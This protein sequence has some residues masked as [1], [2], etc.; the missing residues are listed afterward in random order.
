MS[1]Q[2]CPSLAELSGFVLGT[3]P[4]PELDKVAQHLDGCPSCEAAALALEHIS[5]PVVAAIRHQ[6]SGSPDLASHASDVGASLPERLGDFR[7]LREIGRG[8]MGLVYEAEQVSLSRRVALKVL[9]RRALLEAES[10][11][12]FRRESRAAAGLHHTNIVPVFG[13]GEQDGLHYFVM[14]LIPGVGLDRVLREL[15]QAPT[16]TRPTPSQVGHAAPGSSLQAVVQG[17]LSGSLT[18]P[19]AGMT[20]GHDGSP[21]PA[22]THA[23]P[24]SA[25]TAS[26]SSGSGR[27]YWLAVARVGIQV[28][29]ALQHAHAH[30]VIHRDIKPSNLLLDLQGTVWVTDF[31]LA[32]AAAEEQALTHSGDI[33]GTVRYMAPERFEGTSDGR[34][35]IYSLGVTLYELLTFRDAFPSTDRN[36]LLRRMLNTEPPRPRRVN[37]DVPRDLETIVLKGIARDPAH[38]YQTAAE[39]AADLRRFLEDRPVRARQITAPERLWRLCRR[40]P[41]TAG[42]LAALLVV[43]VAGL[44]GVA[45]QWRRAEGKA[46]DEA[47]ARRHAESARE[48]ARAHLYLSGV[49]QA[50]LEWRLNNVAAADRLLDQC[51]T[52]RRGW[53]WHYLRGVNRPELATLSNPTL[54]MLFGVAFSP[55][56]RL[57]AFTGWDYYRNFQAKVPTPVEVWDI[58]SGKRVHTLAATG[59]GLHP[60]FSPDGRILAVHSAWYPV[61]L[62][63]VAT[64]K[65]LQ[66]WEEKGGADFS[67]DGRLLAVGGLKDI[68][69]REV[70]TGRLVHHFPSQRGR[71]HFSP[72]GRL[73]AVCAEKAVELRAAD[74]GAEVGRLPFGPT[75]QV[76]P[77][78][79][80]LGADV[81]FSPDGKLL[82]TATNPPRVWDVAA[83]RPLA[84]LSGHAGIVPGVAF[85]PDGRHIATAGADATVRLWDAQTGVEL[86]VLRGHRGLVACIAFHPDGW[87]LATGGRQPGDVKL[88]DLTRHPEHVT[89]R[90]SNPH[91]LAFDAAGRLKVLTILGRIRSLDPQSGQ[92]DDGPRIQLTPKVVSP[93]TLAVFTG[94]SRLVAA[95]SAD[96]HT[97]KVFDAA[98]GQE[99]AALHGLDVMPRHVAASRDGSRVAAATRAVAN[100]PP[101]AVQVW[102]TVTGQKLARFQPTSAPQ[103]RLNAVVA[104]S[105]D[106]TRVA[107]DDHEVEGQAGDARM[108]T[109]VRICDA[110]TGEERLSL[111]AD[112]GGMGC[113]AFSED[114]RLLAGGEDDGTVLIWDAAT[115]ERRCQDQVEFAPLS[116]AFNA[117]GRRLAAAGREA[118]ALWDVA[119]GKGILTLRGAQPRPTDFASNA[120]L[121]WSRDGRYLAASNWDGSI[122]VWDGNAA[123]VPPD[124]GP[125][126]KVPQARVYAWHLDQ[127]EAALS[128][129]QMSAAAFHLDHLR[130]AEPPDLLSRRRRGRL[131]LRH[132]E[133][134][135]AAADYTAVFAAGE[136]D[137]PDPW[138]DHARL[139][140]LQGD[141]AGYRRL[142]PRLLAHLGGAESIARPEQVEARACV[143]APEA[144]ADPATALLRA[145]R[146]IKHPTSNTPDPLLSLALT[147]YRAGQW[148][149]AVARL[150]EAMG[151]NP[152]RAWL[153]WPVLAMCHARLGHMEEARRWLEKAE[154]WKRQEA[155]RLVQESTGFAPPEWADFEI[156]RRE[157]AVLIGS[158]KP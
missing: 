59:G 93:A 79:P 106:G 36:V 24:A 9:P 98:T 38:R 153:G 92:A 134:E 124:L 77:Y 152:D 28:A 158:G 138:L 12:R 35:D 117:D 157:A 47:D 105:P 110:V 118:V 11:A 109:R 72:D 101:R 123:E 94:D 64:G 55:D 53:E 147:H 130:G 10:L 54:S 119:T 7:I 1:D 4:G 18:A 99:R 27:P 111:P 82:V 81:A 103:P 97:V 112:N 148:E 113:L 107:F 8:G 15:K 58:R 84:T 96:L 135:E 121:A 68:S 3:L 48:E 41:K 140:V 129:R 76:D 100:G 136:P 70:A 13:T 17:L 142:I 75:D 29:E 14:Q 73:L 40:D 83:R 74:T 23:E 5:D 51:E 146:V 66:T 141:L 37:P 20:A 6:G 154:Q 128:T 151:K 127:A 102:D 88:W 116:M 62:W 60:T 149:Q 26:T 122:A 25:P 19:V 49:A 61:Q 50:R 69:V 85:S 89:L 21:I 108:R 80:E 44:A 95:V 33:I 90:W 132:G 139:V 144:L 57:F 120:T 115:G 42:L 45:T 30:G 63:D 114:G 16:A 155:K 56:R 131:L 91:A 34:G 43:L 137:D 22:T 126:Q 32:K 46:R 87:C 156:L 31:G 67:P 145:Q 150:E 125:L 52:E 65:L 143:L 133:W 104:L 2:A 39:L 78:F 86:A 71:V